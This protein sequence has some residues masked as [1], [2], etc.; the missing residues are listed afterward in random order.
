MVLENLGCVG[1]CGGTV[2]LHVTRS[3]RLKQC[4]IP[5]ILD[6]WS[7]QIELYLPQHIARI[8]YTLS[9]PPS[10]MLANALHRFL[11]S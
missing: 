1:I 3:R 5:S 10:A 2:D 6:P 9:N 4:L 8:D 11:L 7:P